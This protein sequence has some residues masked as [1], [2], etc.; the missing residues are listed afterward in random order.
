MPRS[1]FTGPFEKRMYQLTS[2]TFHLFSSQN[3]QKKLRPIDFFGLNFVVRCRDF[4]PFIDILRKPQKRWKNNI[5]SEY[6][7]KQCWCLPNISQ[8]KHY[9]GYLIW[10]QMK[11]LVLGYKTKWW[12]SLL[13]FSIP[14]IFK[15]FSFFIRTSKFHS[16][17]DVP[18]YI[19]L[20]LFL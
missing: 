18:N 16:I 4:L 17:L 3:S 11:V 2:V 7:E 5:P 19:L 6:F 1:G 14:K 15:Y 8:N 12:T 13:L 20:D 10:F 9:V